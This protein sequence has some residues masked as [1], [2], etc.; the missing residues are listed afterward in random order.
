MKHESTKLTGRTLGIIG[1][2]GSLAGGDLFSKL[3]RSQAVIADQGNYHFLFEQHPFKDVLL[4]LDR[5]ANT[6]SR[7]FYV[8]KVCEGFAANGVNGVLLPCFASHTFRE[9]VQAELDIP[10]FDLL[11]ALRR[12]VECTVQPGARLGILTSDFVRHAGLFEKYFADDYSL[13][14][15][16]EACQA[17]LMDAVYGVQGLKDGFVDGPALEQLHRACL[18]LGGQDVE[19]ILPGMTELSLVSEEL[20]RRGARLLDANQLYADYA[21]RACDQQRVPAFKLGVVGGVGPAATVDFVAKVIR[22]TPATRD[23]DHIKM[24]IEQNPQIPDRTASLLHQ[25]TDPTVAM[26]ATCKKLQREGA[27]AIAI[28]CNTAHA[29]VERIQPYLDI[30]IINM[31]SETIAFIVDEHGAGKTVGLLATSGTITSAVYHVAAQAAGVHLIVPTAAAQAKVM[32]AIYGEYGVKAGFTL[33]QCKTDL[34]E[35][36]ADL[37]A[38]GATVLILGCT[39]LPLVLP[40]AEYFDNDGNVM[41]LVDPTDILARSCVKH[42]LNGSEKYI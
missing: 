35:A 31:L 39:E 3:I 41:A 4:P 20:C 24:V 8:F 25:Q 18:E 13:V 40:Y 7:K 22:H 37:G 27:N 19:L 38:Q 10:V 9:E 32:S 11:D 1:G 15:P 21:T 34:L 26:Y 5:H 33:G 23:Q 17:S 42:A 2:L 14:Y 6:T 16:D 12:Q 36:V 28:P 30:P 29:F